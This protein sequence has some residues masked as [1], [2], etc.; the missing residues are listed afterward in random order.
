MSMQG[1]KF[2]DIHSYYDLNLILSQC[3]ISPAIPKTNYIEIPGADGS[4]DLTEALGEVKYNDRTG[5]LVFTVLPSD[6][7][8]EKKSEISNLLN[9]VY[10]EKITLDK[11]PDFYYQGRCSINDWKC[12]KRIG[13]ITVDLKLQPWKLKQETTVVTASTVF[14]M[15]SQTVILTNANKPTIPNIIAMPTT[16]ELEVTFGK[17]VWNLKKGKHTIPEFVL[18]K[19]EN[20][21]VLCDNVNGF[22]TFEYQ[23]GSL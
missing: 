19:G 21:V 4:I 18:K 6:D 23:E 2:N 7:F 14:G 9:G 10:F 8:E 12:D 22:I 15:G 16:G 3:S 17:F 1:V 11:D 13:K 20:V 5:T